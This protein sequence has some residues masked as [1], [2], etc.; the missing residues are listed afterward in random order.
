MSPGST[1]AVV[2]CHNSSRKLKDEL[3][4]YCFAHQQLRKACVC[5]ARYELHSMPRK[6]DRKR[7]WLAAL[8]L[9]YPPKRVYVC[10]F[11]FIDKKPTE[12]HPD[13][14]LYLGY[15]RAPPKKRRQLI[16]TTVSQT[17]SSNID[18]TAQSVPECTV[19]SPSVIPDLASVSTQPPG[20][21]LHSVHTQWEDPSLKDHHQY[22]NTSG[23][24][25]VQDKTTQC[26]EVAFFL[27]QNDADALLYT[28]TALETFN[29][30][31]S[32]LEGDDNN[33]F[34]MPVQD[35][36]LITLMKIKTNRVCSP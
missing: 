33:E 21:H 31:V 12:L 9:K 11:H 5:P 15:D 7:A 26:D 1:C 19:D 10:S 30:L 25:D 18:K 27:L 32:A 22:C 20:P 28:G 17:A 36:V 6:E 24:K 2:G 23:R 34:T 35:Q 29:T 3:E 14:E 16:R 8:K 13:P 4:T